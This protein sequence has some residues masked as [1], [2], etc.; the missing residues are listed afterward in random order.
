MYDMSAEIIAEHEVI[1]VRQEL[2]ERL[3]THLWF[4]GA[5]SGRERQAE[6]PDFTARQG[7][8]ALLV[9]QARSICGLGRL[10]GIDVADDREWSGPPATVWPAMMDDALVHARTRDLLIVYLD[11]FAPLGHD[12]DPTGKVEAI[13]T[14]DRC[15]VGPLLERIGCDEGGV[16]RLMVTC[17]HVVQSA[18]GQ[19]GAG[20]APFVM[21]GDDVVCISHQERFDEIIA[22]ESDLHV[23][24]GADLLEYFLYSGRRGL[25]GRST[26]MTR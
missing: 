6:H 24:R 23:E 9:S 25:P 5:A 19:H 15:V 3:P 2:D 1:A 10:C 11:V 20:P 18:D 14:A 13:E 26:T 8:S 17:D 12:C 7:V 16:G 22:D 21:A 4:W